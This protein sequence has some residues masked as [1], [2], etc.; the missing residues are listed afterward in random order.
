MST[1]LN[2]LRVTGVQAGEIKSPGP[3][4]ADELRK[5]HA[6]WRACNYLAAGMI[7]LRDNPLLRAPLKEEHVK[8]RLLGHWGTTPG[9]N[10]IYAHMNRA[11]RKYDLNAIYVCGPGHGGPG[12]VAST[13]LEGSYSEF[14]PNI[15][16]NEEGMKRL[17]KQFSFPG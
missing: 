16:Q 9:L 12:M 11:I 4:A 8:Q 1:I 13:Y 5:T 7:Y 15:T 17:F 14:Y 10:F 3:L 2:D 6:Y